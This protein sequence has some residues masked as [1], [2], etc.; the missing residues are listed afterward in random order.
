M[1]VVSFDP[2]IHHLAYC[3]YNSDTHDILLWDIADLNPPPPTIVCSKCKFSAKYIAGESGHFCGR[4]LPKN[5]VIWKKQIDKHTNE[6]I[7]ENMLKHGHPI[8]PGLTKKHAV[9]YACDTCVHLFP[10]TVKKKHTRRNYDI[11][12]LHDA[13]YRLIIDTPPLAEILAIAD[14][15]LIENQPVL[16]N[17]TMKSIQ[18]FI[19]SLVRSEYSIKPGREV[20]IRLLNATKKLETAKLIPDSDYAHSS[21]K[22]RKQ[23]SIDIA[24]ILAPEKWRPYLQ[25]KKKADDLADTFLM[26]IYYSRLGRVT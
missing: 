1:I 21:Y 6:Q 3:A 8:P 16:K 19:Y 10:I 12:F 13:V 2:A 26:N 5:S 17:P 11:G 20:D 9:K 4:H 14:A 7:Y 18:M 23:S 22:D 25:S 24:G 15:V